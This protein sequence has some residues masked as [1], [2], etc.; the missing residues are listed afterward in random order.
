MRLRNSFVLLAVVTAVTVL[1]GASSIAWAD[2]LVANWRLSEASGSTSFADSSGN[3]NNGTLVGSDSVISM[4]GGSYPASPVGTGVYFNG[5][6]GPN[7]YINVPYNAALSP[8]TD[9]TLSA[10]VY[11]PNTLSSSSPKEPI[12]SL[13]N[14]TNTS[15]QGA[16]GGNECYQFG[17]SLIST[18]LSFRD[19]LGFG[20]DQYFNGGSS[21]YPS[22]KYTQNQWMLLTVVFDAGP[23]GQNTNYMTVYE[24][25]QVWHSGQFNLNLGGDPTKLYGQERSGGPL[26]VAGGGVTSTANEWLGGLSDLGIWNVRG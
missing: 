12:F 23:V 20:G 15:T 6:S 13:W 11:I 17:P 24:N 10:W 14:P 18:E 22:H 3:G 4:T 16:S 8:T 1:I 7:T 21:A 26:A 2:G 19:Y 5:V 25:G 9:L